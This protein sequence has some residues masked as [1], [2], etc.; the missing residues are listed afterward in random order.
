MRNIQPFRLLMCLLTATVC[1]VGAGPVPAA[2]YD[3]D[4]AHSFIQFRI[5]HLG[6]SILLGRFN[7]LSRQ[8]LI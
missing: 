5:Q 1:L 6:Y 3:I 2:D 8:L 4:P 7:T